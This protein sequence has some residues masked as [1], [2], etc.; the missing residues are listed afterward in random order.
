MAQVLQLALTT[1]QY[2][3]HL[4]MLR[5]LS[6]V[7]SLPEVI[8][9]ACCIIHHSA[10][11][12]LHSSLC[13]NS[14]PGMQHVQLPMIVCIAPDRITR[15]THDYRMLSSSKFFFRWRH[16]YGLLMQQ[17]AAWQMGISAFLML[18]VCL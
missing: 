9:H 4:E 16:S 14:M 15:C 11:Q 17:L 12:M 6:E 1:R 3:A 13:H 10:T 5:S 2:S 7:Y 18:A 8:C